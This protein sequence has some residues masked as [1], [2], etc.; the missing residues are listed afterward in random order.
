M[1]KVVCK[2][3]FGEIVEVEARD[4]IFRPSIYGLVIKGGEILLCPQ[5]D[6]WDYPGGGIDKGEKL[7]SALVREVREETGLTVKVSALLDVSDNFFQPTFAK[8]QHWHSIKIYYV[9]EYVSGE[10]SSDG[11][12]EYEKTYMK[13]A[14]WVPLD[15]AMGLKFFNSSDNQKLIEAAKA[16]CESSSLR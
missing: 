12:M 9:C 15:Q 11:F 10:I 5:W 16:H 4:L 6:G 3:L 13:E 2:G 14:K 7:E 1:A 8:D